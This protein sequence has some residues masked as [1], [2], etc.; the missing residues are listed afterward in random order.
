MKDDL[1]SL[2]A[3]KLNLAEHGVSLHRGVGKLL[4]LPVNSLPLTDYCIYSGADLTL[5]SDA[6]SSVA[7]RRQFSCSDD[8]DDCHIE[9]NRA[10]LSHSQIGLTF[11]S[12]PVRLSTAAPITHYSVTIPLAGTAV[13]RIGDSHI[14]TSPM[15]VCFLSAGLTLDV[16]RS[17]NHLALILALNAP[18]FEL[19]VGDD[20]DLL[21]SPE[22]PFALTIDLG[23]ERLMTFA[24]VLGTLL[25]VLNEQVDDTTLQDTVIAKIEQALWYKFF[26]AAP[27]IKRAHEDARRVSERPESVGRVIDF[28]NAHASEDITMPQLVAVSGVSLRS[29]HTGFRQYFGYGPM[30]F[31]RKTKLRHCR[32]QLLSANSTEAT[33]GDIAAEWGF[34]QL[35][36]FARNYRQEFGELPSETLSRKAEL[37]IDE[38]E[39]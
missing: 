19:F 4:N 18:G 7:E 26:S 38:A 39:F 6:I 5:A 23:N 22:Q 11:N 30:A 21:A 8:I 13:Y 20:A 2:Y 1:Y 24:Y 27:E 28:V 25:R 16:Q 17:A 36:N 37:A 14:E 35:S 32:E 10:K 33:V 31:V 9:I 34:F 12:R 29:L 15:Q 3:S